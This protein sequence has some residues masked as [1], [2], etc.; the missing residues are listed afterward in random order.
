MAETQDDSQK[1]EE[2]TQRRQEEAHQR[3]QVAESREVNHAFMLLAGALAML[4]V[5]PSV[6]TDIGV[7]LRGFL[8]HAHSIPVDLA[9]L[10]ELAARTLLEILAAVLVPLG[11][12]LVAAIGAGLVQHGLVYAP[13]RIKP[14]FENISPFAGFKR[15]F[16]VR[17][18]VEFGKGLAKIAV[19]GAVA[20][21]LLWPQVPPIVNTPGLPVEE[22]LH[23][24]HSLVMRLFIGII[25]VMAV[26]AGA[27]FLFQR[28]QLMRQLRMSRQEL[29]DEFKQTEGDPAIKSRLR[30]LRQERARKRMMAA[31]PKASVVVT[32]P[33]H[34]AI[35]LEYDRDAMAAPKLV[36]K[37][38]D[39]LALRIRE[40]AAE[41][42]VPIVENAPLARAL[43]ASVE[44]DEEIPTEHY[45][46]VAQIIGYVMRLKG[47]APQQAPQSGR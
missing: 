4:A 38:V 30:Q 27:D 33:T 9:A 17:S 19:V 35:A 1:T 28:F 26:I 31:V 8:E 45:R 37:G 42:S 10:V 2:P 23:L 7:I 47:K 22:Q 5:G 40:V 21:A 43:Y 12:V 46:A 15:L 44:I 16:G 11:L 20:A 3:G 39:S 34:F 6:T 14:K 32:N 24:I 18:W 29:K 13:D 25:S 36:A 41:H